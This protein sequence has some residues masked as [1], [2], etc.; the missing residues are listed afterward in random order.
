MSGAGLEELFDRYRSGGDLDALAEVFD[1]TADQLLKVARHLARDEAQAEDLVQATFLAAIEH[2]ERFDASRELVPWLVGILTN[3]AQVA[4]AIASRAADP[5]R[6]AER[7]SEDPAHGTEIREFMA[8]LERALERVPD[9]YRQVLRIHLAEGKG[10]EEIAHEVKRPASTVRVQLHRGL[11]ALRRLLPAGFALG[12]IVV[13]TA[14]RGL[15][16]MRAHVLGRA[17]A[18]AQAGGVGPAGVPGAGIAGGVLGGKKIAVVV[19]LVV[20]AL[21]VW[22]IGAS[23]VRSS[24]STGRSSPTSELEK[25][26]AGRNSDERGTS[27]SSENAVARETAT[28]APIPADEPYGSLE[29]EVD[30]FD[31]SPA[32]GVTVQV[33]PKEE[34]QP[35][36]HAEYARTN[37]NGRFTILRIHVG[38]AEVILD[39][40]LRFERATVLTVG[41]GRNFGKVVALELRNVGGRVLD[42]DGKP[43]RQG[44][45]WALNDEVLGSGLPVAQTAEDGT[46]HIRAIHPRLSIF[47]TAPNLGSSEAVKVDSLSSGAD[48]QATAELHLIGEDSTLEGVV[49]DAAGA[50]V[51]GARVWT[52]SVSSVRGGDFVHW[53]PTLIQTDADGKFS[54][55]GV[56]EPGPKVLVDAAGFAAWS[57]FQKVEAGK[58][59]H[60]DVKLERGFTVDGTVKNEDGTPSS[61]S[62]VAQQFEL[63]MTAFPPAST[64][65][66]AEGRYSLEH[67]AAGEIT[68]S[69]KSERAHASRT[70]TGQ[71]GDTLHWSPTFSASLVIRG[72]AEDENGIPL[73]GW[74][75]SARPVDQG[76]F[77]PS[78]AST[79][80]QGH[81]EIRGCGN[82]P[83]IVNLFAPNMPNASS[84]T[85]DS[86]RPDDADLVL[87]VTPESRPSASVTGRILDA[88]GVPLAQVVV[89]AQNQDRHSYGQ[90]TTDSDGRFRVDALI[91]GPNLVEVQFPKTTGTWLGKIDLVAEEVRDLGTMTLERRGRLELTLHREDGGKYDKDAVFLFDE[92]GYV[93]L[94]GTK[95]GVLFKSGEL[96]PGRYRLDTTLPG[97]ASEMQFLEVQPG[98]TTRLERTVRAGTLRQIEFHV[99]DGG[100]RAQKLQVTIRRDGGDVVFDRACG[101]DN[102]PTGD[103][104]YTVI[105]GFAVGRYT[106]EATSKEGLSAKGSFEVADLIQSR[107]PMTINLVRDR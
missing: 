17:S 95:D 80:A 2:A 53:P 18:L 28:G 16:A 3:K 98:E 79:D 6:F 68:L 13:L 44:T 75:V 104:T 7:T 42:A 43:V 59:A 54:V 60:L 15:A 78:D 81:F 22:Q 52:R 87:V 4:R 8:T 21:G 37:E 45:V 85:R 67:L 74:R 48:G 26:A 12:G 31:G 11:K 1:R 25:A 41:R 93:S 76:G 47:A 72:R 64:R 102:L 57:G 91:P 29:V 94:A 34:H 32:A 56:H 89:M 61:G 70:F 58:T 90:S 46:F 65:T 39:R 10:A 69:V 84:V 66:D 105:A 49:T 103:P 71:S 33:V 36:Q 14:P 9:A 99:T 40:V 24:S 96:R 77:N 35:D 38:R 107:E 5:D 19:G 63:G 27:L 20:L 106:Y 51:A 83:H 62:S 50:P 92:F 82:G 55:F 30:W 86:V 97:T 88:D 101:F 100:A 23:R 73:A